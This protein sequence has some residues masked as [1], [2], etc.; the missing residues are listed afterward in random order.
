MLYSY[1]NFK[2]NVEERNASDQAISDFLDEIPFKIV[3]L[4]KVN[5][6]LKNVSAHDKINNL[7]D[8]RR[9]YS[10]KSYAVFNIRYD[11][12]SGFSITD[13]KNEYD[14]IIAISKRY[15]RTQYRSLKLTTSENVMNFAQQ[16]CKNFI[17]M[18]AKSVIDGKC[19]DVLIKN[20]QQIILK[21]KNIFANNLDVL[22]FYIKNN[23]KCNESKL[24]NLIIDS[25][26]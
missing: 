23:A 3:I 8:L 5:E 16:L 18:Y 25:I 17:G 2:I 12:L 10:K 9:K 26:K 22:K 7:F 21:Q 24:F 6:K 15:I 14:G 4:R 13:E 20:E 1:D 11:E 19:Y